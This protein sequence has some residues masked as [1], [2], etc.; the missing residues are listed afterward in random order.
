MG[1]VKV[2]II[3]HLRRKTEDGYEEPVYFGAALR[4]VEA[5]RGSRNNNFEEQFLIGTDRIS[6]SNYDEEG[7]LVTLT[8]YYP[9]EEEGQE[10][11]N[12]NLGTYQVENTVYANPLKNAGYYFDNNTFV[13]SEM[14]DFSINEETA[15]LNIIGADGNNG[16]YEFGEDDLKIFP[17]YTYPV[18][19]DILR[20]VDSEGNKTDILT[21]T[22]SIGYSRT[23]QKEISREKIVNHLA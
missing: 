3:D 17:K 22:T 11:E 12:A 13:V 6:T 16:L 14:G 21:K 5:S 7:N 1:K 10:K 9:Q 8:E 2:D 20:F 23:R 18:Q 15:S 4:F 19:Q